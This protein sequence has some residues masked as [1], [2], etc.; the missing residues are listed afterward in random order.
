MESDGA[1]LLS[2]TRPGSK[3]NVDGN[4]GG[5]RAVVDLQPEGIVVLTQADGA[6]LSWRLD[7]GPTHL[8]TCY[9]MVKPS[10][11]SKETITFMGYVDRGQR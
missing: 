6:G 5:P 4:G 11:A 3:A 9:I 7:P 10:T 8:D 1:S 2:T